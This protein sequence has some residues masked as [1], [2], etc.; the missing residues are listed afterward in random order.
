MKIEKIFLEVWTI[1]LTTMSIQVAHSVSAS[2]FK[3]DAAE[4][5]FGKSMFLTI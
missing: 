5:D 1:Y 4:I 3:T 2:T